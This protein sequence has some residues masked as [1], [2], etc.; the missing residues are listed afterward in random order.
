MPE[1]L[2]NSY[3]IEYKENN[4]YTL[5]I[6]YDGYIGP[7]ARTKFMFNDGSYQYILIDEILYCN[8]TGL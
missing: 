8:A 5:C 1:R 7:K 2:I 4:T 6:G 3:Y